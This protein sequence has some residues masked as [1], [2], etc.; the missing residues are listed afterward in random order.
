MAERLPRSPRAIKTI[1]DLEAAIATFAP[2][3]P[4]PEY[5]VSQYA[6]RNK[7]WKHTPSQHPVLIQ[8]LLLYDVQTRQAKNKLLGKKLARLSP[9]IY[10]W[11]S[12]PPACTTP[13]QKN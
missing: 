1:K 11:P 3:K 2:V 7:R 10:D 9:K 5:E 12:K 8:D 4:N 6:T 13:P